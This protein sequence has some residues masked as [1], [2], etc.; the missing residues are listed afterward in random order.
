ML[1]NYLIW[2]LLFAGMRICGVTSVKQAAPDVGRAHFGEFDTDTAA[3]NFDRD[4]RPIFEKH[5]NPCHF[6]GGTLYER[7]P[8]DQGLTILKN[9]KGILPR[10]TDTAE[11]KMILQ[12]VDENSASIAG[13]ENQ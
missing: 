7:L 5:C 2:I 4:I 12:F 1:F 3:L 13:T 11:V 6:P 8:F 10:I 9:A